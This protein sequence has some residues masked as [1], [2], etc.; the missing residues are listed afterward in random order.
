MRQIA[1][2]GLG[3]F[4]SAIAK[5]LAKGG[6]EV[7]AVDKDKEKV[8][9]IKEYVTVAVACNSTDEKTLKNLG[10]ENVD[11]AVVAIGED[12]EAAL[13][14][15]I[16]LKKI[17]VPSIFSRA[18]TP[19]QKEILKAIGVD[20]IIEVEEEM[21]KEIANTIIAPKF[22]KRVALSEEH[23]I[24]EIK[25]PEKFVGKKISELKLRQKNKVNIVAIKRS[26]PDIDRANGSRKFKEVIDTV[27]DPET[28]F[29]ENDIIIIAGK[30]KDIKKLSE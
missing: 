1:I 6:A 23:A 19:T 30:D 12:V 7:I 20:R 26:V 5:S 3:S 27:P 13:L 18:I 29:D 28:I 14:T 24:V 21:G 22:L 15:T 4:G 9:E 16:L 8:E 17:G 11:I 10:L 2:F 25:V